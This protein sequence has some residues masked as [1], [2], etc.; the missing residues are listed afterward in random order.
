MASAFEEFLFLER[1]GKLNIL[2]VRNESQYH[3]V[4]CYS[5]AHDVKKLNRIL[6]HSLSATERIATI[7]SLLTSYRYSKEEIC[8]AWKRC[9][10][11]G[12][13]IYYWH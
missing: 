3:A 7:S 10:S 11:A 9:Y 6:K 1:E 12:S 8:N 13:M 5:V 2:I 4:R